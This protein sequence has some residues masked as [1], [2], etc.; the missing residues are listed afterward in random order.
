MKNKKIYISVIIIFIVIIS[1]V[2]ILILNKNNNKTNNVDTGKNQDNVEEE[3]ELTGEKLTKEELNEFIEYFNKLENNGF[4]TINYKKPSEIDLKQVLYTGAGISQQLTDN[5]LEEYKRLTNE[6]STEI[7]VIA[8]EKE[9]IESFYYEKTGEKLENIDERLE[10]WTYLQD[11]NL[12]CK[13]C[14]DSNFVKVTG[15]KAGAKDGNTYTIYVELSDSLNPIAKITLEKKGNNYIFKSNETGKTSKNEQEDT[16]KKE[17]VFKKD[18]TDDEINQNFNLQFKEI[19]EELESKIPNPDQY[20]KDLKRFA[21]E[22]IM[23]VDTA[24]VSQYNE[25]EN[26]LSIEYCLKKENKVVYRIFAIINKQDNTYK[27]EYYM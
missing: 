12:Y 21:Y 10:G 1:V 23:A 13:T 16:T 15:C 17:F 19:S 5:Q 14:A 2:L 26:S 27:F 4:V 25:T 11:S 18:A 8:I 6:T 9:K 22:R 7:N 3:Y 20:Y 24:E